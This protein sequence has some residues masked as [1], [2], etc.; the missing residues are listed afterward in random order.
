M[1]RHTLQTHQCQFNCKIIDIKHNRPKKEGSHLRFNAYHNLFEIMHVI[2]LSFIH[3]AT[4]DD[5]SLCID[6]TYSMAL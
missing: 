6:M 4:C 2:G 1:T 3:F 5:A